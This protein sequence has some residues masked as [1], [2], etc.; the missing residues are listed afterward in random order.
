MDCHFL[1]QGI[2]PTQESN[3]GL[4][5]CRQTLYRLSHQGSP[6]DR[7]KKTRLGWSGPKFLKQPGQRFYRQDEL[8]QRGNG[9]TDKA[10][11]PTCKW[12]R[13]SACRGRFG[14]LMNGFADRRKREKHVLFLDLMISFFPFQSICFFMCFM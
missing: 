10:G 7:L 4:L 6:E 12:L 9:S 11:S 5:H 3:P 2:F 14:T 13:I 8:D 1:L